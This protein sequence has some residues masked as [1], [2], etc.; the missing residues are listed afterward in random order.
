[1]DAD[2]IIPAGAVWRFLPG[3]TEASAPDNRLWRTTA[4]D[5]AAF[6]N[7][8]APFTYGEGYTNGTALAAML[9][10]YSCVFL[11]CPLQ[12]T[13]LAEIAALRL[14]AKV[15]ADGSAGQGRKHVSFSLN[16]LGDTLLL[17]GTNGQTVVDWV[18]FGAQLFGVSAGSNETGP[19]PV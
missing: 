4:F 18:A 17:Y 12:I 7:A 15:V 13:N 16:G 11:R 14:E 9:N 8:P 10:N 3:V 19:F 2:R 6:T 5:D 1:M